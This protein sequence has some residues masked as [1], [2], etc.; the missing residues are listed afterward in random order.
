MTNAENIKT[1]SNDRLAVFLANVYFSG[2]NAENENIGEAIKN[3]KKWLE[4][5]VNYGKR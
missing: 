2:I 5:E 4:S 1:M 3:F